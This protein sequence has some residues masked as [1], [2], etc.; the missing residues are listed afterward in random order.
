[1]LYYSINWNNARRFQLFR[2]KIFFKE[3]ECTQSVNIVIK[4]LKKQALLL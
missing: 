4:P 3:T 1:M 2:I